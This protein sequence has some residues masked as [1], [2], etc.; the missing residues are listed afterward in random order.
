MKIIFTLA[1]VGHAC[2][3]Q[4]CMIPMA[5]AEDITAQYGAEA[6]QM[7]MT[8][9]EPMSPARCE[10]CAHA[11][12]GQSKPVNASCAGHCFSQ[13]RDVLKAFSSDA[14]SFTESAVLHPS[15][16]VIISAVDCR[17]RSQ[18]VNWPP[19][20]SSFTRTIVLLQ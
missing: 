9:V 2:L 11:Y 13:T 12:K 14:P 5:M 16:T 10:H 4:L 15:T 3:A 1:F 6:M 7:T 8:P 20:D 17:R 19:G 18:T